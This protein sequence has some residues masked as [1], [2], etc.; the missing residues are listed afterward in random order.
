VSF[1]EWLACSWNGKSQRGKVDLWK[2]IHDLICCEESTFLVG[3]RQANALHPGAPR[4]FDSEWSVF[5]HHTL[6][7]LRFNLARRVEE[8]IG[9]R[10]RTKTYVGHGVEMFLE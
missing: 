7:W 5:D 10:L 2:R 6:L 9:P 3:R 4:C 1:C 8:E